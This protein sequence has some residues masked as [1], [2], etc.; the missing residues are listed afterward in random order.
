MS[1][2]VD[3]LRFLLGHIEGFID[4][5]ADQIRE[6]AK[7]FSPETGLENIE[8]I[9]EPQAPPE[10]VLERLSP[11]YDCGL[12][13]RNLN[14]PWIV[15]GLFWRG[16]VFPLTAADQRRADHLMDIFGPT[17]VG[18]APAEKILKSVQ[19]EFL[20][21]TEKDHFGY[22]LQPAQDC[23]YVLFSR[24]ADPWAKDHVLHT[25]RLLNKAF[26]Y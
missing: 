22:L 12:L 23:A 6:R 13:I 14:G 15:T 10:F 20:L 7:E 2:T 26:L 3:R 25:Q 9:A 19:L 8:T 16:T 11:F 24:L 18:R 21:G 1:W 4:T 5:E 17:K